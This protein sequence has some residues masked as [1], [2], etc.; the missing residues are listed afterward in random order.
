MFGD[1]DA[2]PTFQLKLKGVNKLARVA[3]CGKHAVCMRTDG[4]AG[5]EGDS[6]MRCS[7]EISESVSW[8][9]G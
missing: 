2:L 4:R 9:Y 8:M 5:R 7:R 1:N 6:G 3:R